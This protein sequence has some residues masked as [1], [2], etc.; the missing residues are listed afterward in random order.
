[1]NDTD[2]YEFESRSYVNPQ[3]SLDENNT[4]INNLRST[5]AADANRV[6]AETEA[7]GTQVPSQLGGLGGG[8]ESQWRTQY[9]TPQVNELV[10]GLK[11]AAQAQALNTALSNIQNQES[12]RYKVAYR[13][14]LAR[15][16]AKEAAAKAAAASSNTTT[17]GNVQEEA[18]SGNSTT[19]VISIDINPDANQ[20]NNSNQQSNSFY[21][22]ATGNYGS[23]TVGGTSS[24]ESL[25]WKG[26]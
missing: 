13:D 1:M 22:E 10:S 15:E 21:E 24:V 18:V 2:I 8:A 3:A 26:F 11:A 4:F 23:N 25:K 7:M 17:K 19:D 9:E 14:Y 5:Q 12:Q 16:R 20:Y 6:A